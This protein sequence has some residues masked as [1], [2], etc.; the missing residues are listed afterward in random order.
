MLIM[1]LMKILLGFMHLVRE[2]LVW[3]LKFC[4]LVIEVQ[5]NPSYSKSLTEQSVGLF[6]FHKCWLCSILLEQFTR[7]SMVSLQIQISSQK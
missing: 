2:E 3:M 6:A 5:S 4:N 1:K 7:R